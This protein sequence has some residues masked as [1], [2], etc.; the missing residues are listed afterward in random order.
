MVALILG[1]QGVSTLR[2]D[3][4]TEPDLPTT[5]LT[6]TDAPADTLRYDQM[7]PFAMTP[8]P[9]Q[10]IDTETLWLARC[11]YSETKQPEEQ[12]LVAWVLRNRVE[13]GYRGRRTYRETVLDPYQFSAFNHNSEKRAF[14]LSLGVH[15]KMPGWQRALQIANAVRHAPGE[16][17]PFPIDTRHFFSEVAMP[18]G[19]HPGWAIDEAPVTPNRSFPLDER[20]FRFFGGIS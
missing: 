17:R 4:P 1:L 7:P 9:P 15:S 6:D 11:I 8:L 14:Y 10:Q 18:G 5:T 19:R 20:R 2:P 12:E 3:P 13:T 16:Y